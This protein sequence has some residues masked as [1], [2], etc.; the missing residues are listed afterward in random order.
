MFDGL[1][2]PPLNAAQIKDA[3]QFG[4]DHYGTTD[5]MNTPSGDPYD[6]W[7][8]GFKILV[9]IATAYNRIAAY[10]GQAD[11]VGMPLDAATIE[12]INLEA[13]FKEHFAVRMISHYKR[14][15]I[16]ATNLDD[17]IPQGMIQAVVVPGERGQYNQTCWFLYPPQNMCCKGFEI[18]APGWFGS[19]KTERFTFDFSDV[20]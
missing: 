4:H 11:R 2:I 1:W 15:S 5:E 18:G 9:S 8:P 7:V 19:F 14:L 13:M 16:M 17:G 20:H 6:V 3:V 10:V 12:A